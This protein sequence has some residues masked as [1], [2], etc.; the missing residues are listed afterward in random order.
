M[1]WQVLLSITERQWCEVNL[2]S[3]CKSGD[4]FGGSTDS[5]AASSL[6]V[7]PLKRKKIP[8]YVRQR[9]DSYVLPAFSYCFIFKAWFQHC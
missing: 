5:R 3:Q 8:K 4:I 1:C 9:K 7:G 6:T 2:L